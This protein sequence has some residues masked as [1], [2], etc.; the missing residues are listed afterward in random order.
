MRTLY[1]NE[2]NNVVLVCPGCEKTKVFN[3]N[4]HDFP[5]GPLKLTYRFRCDDC[6]CGHKDCKECIKNPCTLG[7]V[8]TVRLERRR[9]IR[10]ETEL[11]GI[12]TVGKNDRLPVIIMDLSRT[13]ALIHHSVPGCL[14]VGDRGLLD[15]QLDDPQNTRV[16]KGVEVIRDLSNNMALRFLESESF[17]VADK[18]IGFYLMK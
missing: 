2:E 15:F 3:I 5:D 1:V 17:S 9:Y 12:F 6:T 7:H 14:K 11:T 13:G 8:N 4:D 10:K 16:Q 18:A